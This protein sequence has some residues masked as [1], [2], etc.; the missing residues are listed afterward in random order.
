MNTFVRV[1]EA[2]S[3]TMAAQHLGVAT[4]QVSRAISMLESHLRTRLLNRT[5]RRIALTEAGQRYRQR[6]MEILAC[7]DQA[8]AEAAD[9]HTVPKGRLRIH[10]T[11]SFGQHYVVPAIARYQQGNPGVSVELTL[12]Q[13]IPDL[14]EEGYD[15]ALAL[16]PALLDS[17]LVSQHLG[18]TYSVLCAAPAYLQDHGVPQ[19]PADLALYN[20][21]RLMSTL[22]PTDSWHVKGLSEE[23]T[24]SFDASAFQVNTAEALAAWV[25]GGGGIAPLP[26]PCA[27]PGL[28]EGTLIRVLPQYRLQELNVYALYASRQYLDAKIRTWVD[29]LREELPAILAGDEQA[30]CA[31]SASAGRP[32]ANVAVR[33]EEVEMSA[34]GRARRDT[35]YRQPE[36]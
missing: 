17:G 27:L 4:A 7:V 12:A 16:A 9:A 23:E 6:C 28:R 11:A 26:I 29:L 25:R 3:F 24:I 31:L 8:E 2:G 32:L 30:L 15:I 19:K 1:C 36:V 13:R 20:C 33:E 22:F 10:A 35:S 34:R 5:T 18:R 21:V 14:L